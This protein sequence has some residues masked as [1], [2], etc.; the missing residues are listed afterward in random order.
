MI[1]SSDIHGKTVPTNLARH[2]NRFT[3]YNKPS[4]DYIMLNGCR[5]TVTTPI[6]NFSTPNVSI[7][8]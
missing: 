8:A 2:I 4:M 6:F 7:H 1:I 5:T 3:L